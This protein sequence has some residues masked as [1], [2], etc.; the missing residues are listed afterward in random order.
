M[1]R[2]LLALIAI[3]LL[4]TGVITAGA[5]DFGRYYPETGHTLDPRFVRYFDAH[6]GLELLGYPI[7]DSFLDARSG[8]IV[9]Y[10]TNARIELAPDPDT[11]QLEVRLSPL[12]EL[13]HGWDPPAEAAG[14]PIGSNPGCEFFAF[15][16]LA[17]LG[18]NVCHA[19]LA[20][21][22][23]RGGPAMLGLPISDVLL[24]NDRIVQYFQGFRLD[25]YPADLAGAQVRIAPLGRAHFEVMG[26]D[27][28]LRRPRL[29]NNRALYRVVELYPKA[30]MSKPVIR[31]GEVQEIYVVV[32]D[33]NLQP[34]EGVAVAV[35]LHFPNGDRALMMKPTGHNGVSRESVTL[36]DQ[37]PGTVVTFEVWA[38][39]AEFQST[40][41]DSFR[42]W[43]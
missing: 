25:W 9:Q 40:T 14:F 20:F 30:S 17:G 7:T 32:W 18:Y 38:T 34:V 24:E 36:S 35:I 22:K 37:S 16:E 27:A 3:F 8:L 15:D 33:Q 41:R 6:G 42:V 39:Y 29:P 10:F 31:P 21:Y 28:A 12:G 2:L 43:W 13:L 19:F 11:G 23:S 26:Y 1:Q 5:Q 4:A